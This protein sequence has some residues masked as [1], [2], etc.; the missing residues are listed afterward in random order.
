MFNIQIAI[1][2]NAYKY[3]END[4]DMHKFRLRCEMNKETR[5]IFQILRFLE[6]VD[7]FILSN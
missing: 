3:V 4:K 5:L 7:C 2:G 6:P 1:V